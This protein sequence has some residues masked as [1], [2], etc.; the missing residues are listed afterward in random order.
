MAKPLRIEVQNDLKFD[1]YFDKW[2]LEDEK[3]RGKVGLQAINWVVSGSP[4]SSKT[5]PVLT[6]LLRGSGSAFVGSKFVG[7]T[8]K[9]NGEGNPNK[10]FSE[11]KGIITVGFNTPYAHRWHENKFIPGPVSQRGPGDVGD[12]YLEDHY[13]LSIL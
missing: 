4:N 6:G 1:V 8:P 3:S 13:D 12:K 10:S 5:P 7:A 2:F 9:F 11:Q